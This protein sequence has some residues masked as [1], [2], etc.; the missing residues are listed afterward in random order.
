M[1]RLKEVSRFIENLDLKSHDDVIVLLQTIQRQLGDVIEELKNYKDAEELKK[2]PVV[3]DWLY[4]K[5]I[6]FSVGFNEIVE[7]YGLLDT[8][9]FRQ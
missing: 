5:I 8:K 3:C 7:F 4:Y 6:D 2:D 1:D 9:L